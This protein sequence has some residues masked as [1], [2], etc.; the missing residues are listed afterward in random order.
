M[1]ST[2]CQSD[3]NGEELS[4]MESELQ[5]LRKEVFQLRQ[6][7]QS[8]QE[9]ARKQSLSPESLE[10]DQQQLKFYTGMYSFYD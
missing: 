7:V 8:L 10:K 9:D 1:V 6:N 3:L 5:E 4:A 2:L